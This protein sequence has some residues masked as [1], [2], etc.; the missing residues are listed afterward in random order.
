MREV[1]FSR[2]FY[3]GNNL[4]YKEPEEK[5]IVVEELPPELTAK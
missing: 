3:D 2:L 5:K 4:F 1:L